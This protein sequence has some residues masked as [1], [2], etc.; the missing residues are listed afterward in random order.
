MTKEQ[1]EARDVE[2]KKR[3]E[4]AVQSLGLQPVVTEEK[5]VPM[6]KKGGNETIT[7]PT[8]VIEKTAQQLKEEE[9]EAKAIASGFVS[10]AVTK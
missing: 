9:M 2:R 1:R 5:K 4:E 8:K 7:P 3:E 10:T 6:F